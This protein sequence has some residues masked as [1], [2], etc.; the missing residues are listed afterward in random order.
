MR[1]MG[2]LWW[3]ILDGRRHFCGQWNTRSIF[4]PVCILPKQVDCCRLCIFQFAWWITVFLTTCWKQKE[5][6]E[7]AFKDED[8]TIPI[9]CLWTHLVHCVL[10]LFFGL[11]QLPMKKSD[12]QLISYTSLFSHNHFI[13]YYIYYW[14]CFHGKSWVKSCQ[15]KTQSHNQK[16]KTTCTCTGVS[17][18]KMYC[19]APF[20]HG[21]HDMM[22][23]LK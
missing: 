5:I 4:Q 14:S 16:T 15:Q 19:S 18:G 13:D 9:W 12:F 21:Q 7:T 2:T 8:V 10:A 20:D 23:V 22:V 6:V 11:H 3:I 17:I 1:T